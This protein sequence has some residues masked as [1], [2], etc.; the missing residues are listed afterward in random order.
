MT[1]DFFDGGSAT[2]I[3]KGAQGIAALPSLMKNEP[4]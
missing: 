1:W 3:F 4:L 2:S